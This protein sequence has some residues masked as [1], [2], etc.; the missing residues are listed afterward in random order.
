VFAFGLVI[1][2]ALQVRLLK[3]TRDD[4]HTQAGW[5]ETQ[6]EH[7]RKQ[8][9][10]SEHQAQ[11]ISVQAGFMAEQTMIL[12]E[13]VA[14]A[15]S[16]ADAANSQI[17]MIKNKERARLTVEPVTTGF[18]GELRNATSRVTA[19]VVIEHYGST[20]A[21]NVRGYYT[22]QTSGTVEHPMESSY[23]GF[24]DVPSV[25]KARGSSINA[26]CPSLSFPPELMV[27]IEKG[28]VYLIFF[29]YISYDDVWGEPQKAWFD[30]Y[31][32]VDP[33]AA[34]QGEAGSSRWDRCDDK[35]NQQ[36]TDDLRN[37]FRTQ[38]SMPQD[39]N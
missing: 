14:A 21:T 25:I 34:E 12:K 9:D 20:D 11:L 15:Q 16:S 27:E 5:M 29:G 4:I 6:T 7:I 28:S 23:W 26:R 8:A 3:Q 18:A 35:R 37:M 24:M 1:V 31:W 30:H 17:Q 22:M 13:S 39:P 33:E 38:D 19:Q 32:R 36:S 10:M 2:G